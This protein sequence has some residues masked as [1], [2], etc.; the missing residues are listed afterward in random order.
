MD[1][2]HTGMVSHE[3]QIYI[4]FALNMSNKDQG[5]I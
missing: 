2:F 1:Y 4:L 3:R 5:F